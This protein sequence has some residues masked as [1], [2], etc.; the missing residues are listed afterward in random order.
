[1][2]RRTTKNSQLRIGYQEDESDE[3]ETKCDSADESMDE[4]SD[5]EEEVIEEASDVDDEI[6][7]ESDVEN[8]LYS[9]VRVCRRRTLNNHKV[10]RS[11]KVFV[12]QKSQSVLKVPPRRKLNRKNA[13]RKTNVS[14]RN[15]KAVLSTK[16]SEKSKVY[17]NKKN[18]VTR[19]SATDFIGKDDTKWAKSKFSKSATERNIVGPLDEVRIPSEHNSTEPIDFFK[20]FITNEVCEE[21]VLRTNEQ[22]L[23]IKS[24]WKM[25][26]AEE[27]YAFFGLL[28]T[29]GQMKSCNQNYRIFWHSYYGS[30]TFPATMGLTRFEDLLRFIRF[31]DKTTRSERRKSDKLCPIRHIWEEVTTNFA[32]YYVP[33]DN[34]TVDE[35]LMPCRCRCSFIQYMPKK[36]DKYGIKIYWLC[37]SKNAYPLAG[38]PYTGKDGDRKA[39]NLGSRIVETLCAPYYGTNRNITTDNYFTSLAL[40][41]TLLSNGLTLVGTLKKNKTCVPPEF[42]PDKTKIEGS[43]MFGFR[44][45]ATLVSHVPKRNK[46]VLFL[47]TKHHDNIIL[48]ENVKKP[49]STVNKLY[50]ETKSGVDTLDQ[51]VHEYMIKRKTNRWPFSFFMNLLDVSNVA[52]YI[53][54]C[55]KFPLWNN[56]KSN[57][58]NLFLRALGEDLVTPLVL[59][60]NSSSRLPASTRD[61]ISKF[62]NRDR[63][64]KPNRQNQ[65]LG[66]TSSLT[67][68]IRKPKRRRCH[69][70]PYNISRMQNQT[71]STCFKNVCKQ[72]SSRECTT[73]KNNFVKLNNSSC[74]N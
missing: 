8:I 26:D 24:K 27:L 19:T 31:D 59:R 41:E 1:M 65:M 56:K 42:L 37:D 15:G 5:S 32:K 20:L 43:T 66:S 38:I 69:L 14:T 53:L 10:L 63:D 47:S 71:C 46:A 70:C 55:K 35:Q 40:A 45:N 68:D 52:A 22:A 73:C 28:I 62:L 13:V 74:N 16:K 51:M 64:H 72:H 67:I 9:N 25:T 44:E 3:E 50:N 4:P 61:A 58:R 60:R 34:L 18:I 23:R 7:C 49:I 21:I 29:A 2:A 12:G 57:K 48:T 33:S 54:W 39:T 17:R 30:P 36:P 11:R 6:S